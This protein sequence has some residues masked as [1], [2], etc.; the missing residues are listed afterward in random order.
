M[1]LSKFLR[2][3]EPPDQSWLVYS[4]EY[5]G[6]AGIEFEDVNDG[7]FKWS[8]DLG[9]EGWSDRWVNARG[10]LRANCKT[11]ESYD[12]FREFAK[13]EIITAKKRLGVL[14]G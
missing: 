2:Y 9:I 5:N 12:V 14:E 4:G 1:Y 11:V 8:K 6:R 3:D 10:H 7:P 13:V